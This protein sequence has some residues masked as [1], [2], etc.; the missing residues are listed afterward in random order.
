MS[1]SKY[2]LPE[3]LISIQKPM[4]RVC[5]SLLPIA[6][7]SIYLFGWRS[8]ALIAVTFIFG[9]AAEAAFTFREGKP[10]TSAVFVTCLIFSLSLP[11]SLPLWMAAIGI[12]VG[13]VIGKMAFGG[14]GLN[15]FNPAMVGRCFI[16]ITFPIEMTSNWAKPFWGGTGGFSLWSAP[17]DTITG[18]TPL[19]QLKSGR[20]ISLT[21]LFIGNTAGSLGETSAFLIILGAI[22]IISSK[23]AS[24]KLAISCLLGAITASFFL[25]TAGVEGALSTLQTLLSGSLLFGAAFV[26]TEPITGAKTMPGQWVYGASIGVLSVIL[27]QFSNFPEGLMFS[28]LLM[29]SIVPIMDRA[30]R[31]APSTV[32]ASL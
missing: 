14:M 29:N 17:I 15:I 28:V 1:F 12:V 31:K 27:R 30:F 8:A 4:M 13:V 6:L 19:S 2:R 16:Y 10:V 5:Y 24:W 22:Y 26:V 25:K 3:K 9:I 23:T 18:A 7:F 11:P 32:K 20:D 21:D